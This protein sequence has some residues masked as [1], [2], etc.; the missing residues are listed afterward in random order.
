[1]AMRQ[2]LKIKCWKCEKEFEMSAEVS[3]KPGP[4]VEAAIPCPFCKTTNQV[5]V[6]ADQVKSTV[7]YRDGQAV[8]AVEEKPGALLGQ[9]FE[10]QPPAET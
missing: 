3:R 9:V 7:L 10:G 4:L 5:T 8:E 2:A 1:M 6:R